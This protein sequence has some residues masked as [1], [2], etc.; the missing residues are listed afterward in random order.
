ML[1]FVAINSLFLGM[2]DY[3]FKGKYSDEGAPLGNYIL[4]ITEP[5]YAVLFTTEALVKIVA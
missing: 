2:V 4:G 3:R 5:I 1:I